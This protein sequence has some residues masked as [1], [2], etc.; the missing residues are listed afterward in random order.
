MYDVMIIGASLGGS[1]VACLLG[2]AGL[3]VGLVER[4]TRL[5]SK[6]CGEGLA[7]VGVTAAE[8]IGFWSSCQPPVPSRRYD[9]F[10]VE[11]AGRTRILGLRRGGATVE[12]RAFDTHV[13]TVAANTPNVNALFGVPAT[14]MRDGEGYA[15]RLGADTVTARWLVIADG[16]NSP[17]ARAL[18]VR[19]TRTA[20]PR[21]G[22]ACHYAGRFSG[23]PIYV[24]ITVE[25]RYEL[26]ATPLPD[27]R[28]NLAVM[29]PWRGG[30]DLR[31]LF[32]THAVRDRLFDSLGF[33]GVP[34]EDIRG[35]A[36]LGGVSRWGAPPG[37]LLVG[38]AAEEF[39]PIGGMGMSHA[40]LSG[41]L[42]AHA[43]LA[44]EASTASD[45]L[46][47]QRRY[48]IDRSLMARP[49]RRFTGIAY[50][51]LRTSRKLPMVLDLA[52]SRLGG[53]VTDRMVP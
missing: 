22:A 17:C 8:R 18:G 13:S 6:P 5:R 20:P 4:A 47:V 9:G 1:A 7:A 36:P 35:R 10:K 51:A 29:A 31:G 42:A 38:D 14:V 11:S 25:D 12:R 21:M 24:H 48:E 2:R 40:L 34:T 39:D 28:L 3:R 50:R 41:E 45:Q 49:L 32:G 19:E 46:T 30:V 37:V 52:A 27:G 16:S 33:E 44:G 23:E 26:Y 15:V 43:I 53:F